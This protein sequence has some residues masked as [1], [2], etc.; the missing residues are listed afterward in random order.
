MTLSDV[1]IQEYL[2]MKKLII[3]PLV[4]GAIQ[5]AS[6]DL[7]LGSEFMKI[8][9][10]QVIRSDHR[11]IYNKC[12]CDEFRIK[13][14]EF[15]LATTIE[16]LELPNN[17][18]GE[19]SGKSSWGRRGLKIENAGFVDPGFKGNLTLEILNEGSAPVIIK[20]GE[21]ICQIEFRRTLT[22]AK[23]PYNGKYV[24]QSGTTG[25]KEDKNE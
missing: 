21:P 22:P 7:R 25:A 10:K 14:G 3:E 1:N 6:V 24:G 20:K 8:E 11:V 9:K 5:P 4:L 19:L 12:K 15:I 23:N 18:V 2:S 13:P 17:I 16:W